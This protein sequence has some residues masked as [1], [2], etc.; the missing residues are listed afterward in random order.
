[1]DHA[2][3]LKISQCLAFGL[4]F[5]YLGWLMKGLDVDEKSIILGGKIIFILSFVLLLWGGS[6]HAQ[7][8]GLWNRHGAAKTLGMVVLVVGGWTLLLAT[9]MKLGEAL[10]LHKRFTG[11][12][13]L[14][15]AEGLLLN[16]VHG[17]GPKKEGNPSGD[18][19]AANPA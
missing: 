1:M 7:A 18:K 17:R 14:V 15:V 12:V 16:W 10:Y 2:H 9:V 5:Q 13:L 11:L 3:K 6:L 19:S 8:R 4:F